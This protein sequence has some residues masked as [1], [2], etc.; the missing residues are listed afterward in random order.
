MPTVLDG[1]NGNHLI[2]CHL[3]VS[4]CRVIDCVH[5]PEVRNSNKA[6]GRISS[7][8]VMVDGAWGMG[9]EAGRSPKKVCTLLV[10]KYD[11]TRYLK[12]GTVSRYIST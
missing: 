7:I 6:E 2:E 8:I 12:Y 5:V 9:R 3:I 11:T 4:G 1:L 10:R